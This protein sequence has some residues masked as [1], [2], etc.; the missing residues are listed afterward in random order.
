MP[1][2]HNLG[3]KQKDT[4]LFVSKEEHKG[5][6]SVDLPKSEMVP[7]LTLPNG[8]INWTCPCLDDMATGPC[9]VEF[10]DAFACFHHSLANPKGKDCLQKFYTMQD[11]MQKFPQTYSKGDKPQST[12]KREQFLDQ[13]LDL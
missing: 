3:L 10:R 8:D 11:C 9:G 5:Q 13:A 12:F 4:V 1:V 2:K 7:G 6:S